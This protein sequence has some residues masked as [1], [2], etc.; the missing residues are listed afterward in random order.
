MTRDN[1]PEPGIGIGTGDPAGGDILK[2]NQRG[3]DQPTKQSQGQ[4]NNQSNS[5]TG[6]GEMAPAI[7][8]TGGG[9]LGVDD[10]GPA[11]PTQGMYSDNLGAGTIPTD[12]YG[13]AEN[14]PGSVGPADTTATGD[15]TENTGGR[16]A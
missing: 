8:A 9:T 15:V 2:H 14:E 7:G 3:N 12:M 13:H 1:L 5:Y 4:G 10:T 16:N 11:A 6:P